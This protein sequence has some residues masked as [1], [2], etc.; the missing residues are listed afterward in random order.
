MKDYYGILQVSQNASPEVIAA[1]Y[2]A[3]SKIHHPDKGGKAADF[4]L[5]NEAKEVLL[6]ADKRRAYDAQRMQQNPFSQPQDGPQ[7]TW[8]NGRGWVPVN[9]APP[10]SMP[11]Y[12]PPYGGFDGGTSM[13]MSPYPGMAQDLLRAYAHSAVEEFLA[14]LMRGRR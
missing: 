2:R 13:G 6:D 3:L 11:P 7:R 4:Q 14:A 8:V 9:E 10:G 5:I 12:P 1:S